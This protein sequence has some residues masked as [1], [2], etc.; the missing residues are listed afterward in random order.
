MVQ[1]SGL[2]TP[3]A[4]H[5]VCKLHKA[6]YTFDLISYMQH[7]LLGVYFNTADQSLF[8]KSN[9]RCIIYLLVYVDDILITGDDQL[10]S[11]S[12]IHDLTENLP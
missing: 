6:L 4:T 8:V 2:E 9:P 1:P 12:L 11:S 3:Q 7:Y 10:A 5:L